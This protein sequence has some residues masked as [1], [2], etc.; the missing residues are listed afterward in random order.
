VSRTLATDQDGLGTD[1]MLWVE[2]QRAIAELMIVR[3]DAISRCIGFA[4]FMEDYDAKYARW[5]EEFAAKLPDLDVPRGRLTELFNLLL[6]LGNA[7]DPQNRRYDWR[8]W[9]QEDADGRMVG[10]LE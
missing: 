4:A 9:Q 3:G 8:E 10:K 7:L 5:F 6:D 1:F 2:E